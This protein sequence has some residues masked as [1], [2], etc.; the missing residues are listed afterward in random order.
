[1]GT[2]MHLGLEEQSREVTHTEEKN[3]ENK[4]QLDQSCGK[5]SLEAGATEHAQETSK[6]IARGIR[7]ET[8]PCVL[9][10]AILLF[11]ECICYYLSGERPREPS[12]LIG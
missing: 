11:I 3:G 12:D 5:I 4:N 7:E 1:M 10:K 6:V 9:G 8:T 2:P